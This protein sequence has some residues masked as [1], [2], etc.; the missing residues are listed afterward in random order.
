MSWIFAVESPTHGLVP[1]PPRTI[2]VLDVRTARDI[3]SLVSLFPS[4]TLGEPLAPS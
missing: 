2:L 3:H 1:S 4:L